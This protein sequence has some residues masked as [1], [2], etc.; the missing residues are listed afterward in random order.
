MDN[1]T[2]TLREQLEE[3]PA[4]E[5]DKL[6]NR[7]LDQEHP[8]GALIRTI[9]EIIWDREKDLPLE[10]T[11]GIRRAWEKYRRSVRQL[12]DWERQARRKR[13]LYRVAATAAVLCLVLLALPGKVRAETLFEKLARWTGSV[14]EFFS[15]ET[16][17]DNRL[18]YAFTSEDPGL[19]QVYQA[20]S[21]LGI[22]DP[23]VPMWLPEGY[24]LVECKKHE[25]SQKSGIAAYFKNGEDM[26]LYK[27]DLYKEDVSHKYHKDE[28]S[29]VIYDRGGVDHKIMR[30]YDRWVVIWFRDKIECSFTVDCPEDT[31]YEILRSIYVT[32]DPDEATD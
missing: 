10:I 26:L 4:Q 11:P 12:E 7:E 29:A 22:T 31:L 6:L 16:R 20:V 17:N 19:Q 1:G 23:V 15:P 27:V 2:N 30:N 32:E 25:T 24:E 5:L 3:L 21:A 13:R 18:E 14:V 28:S 9:M 8:D